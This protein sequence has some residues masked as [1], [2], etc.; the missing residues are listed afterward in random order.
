[1]KVCKYGF[2]IKGKEPIAA[3]LPICEHVLLEFFLATY[4]L[5]SKASLLHG[6]ELHKHLKSEI[7]EL[8]DNTFGLRI[9]NPTFYSIFRSKLRTRLSDVHVREM[10]SASWGS[11]LC[12]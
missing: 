9:L 1:M 8:V 5:F 3:F 10:Q 7:S 2:K 6:R 12:R 11:R 4:V